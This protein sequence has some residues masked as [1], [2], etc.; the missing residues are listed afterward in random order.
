MTGGKISNELVAL[1]SAVIFAVYLAGSVRTEP[2]ASRFPEHAGTRG[3]AVAADERDGQTTAYRNGIYYGWGYSRHGDIEAYVTIES[4]R[5]AAA[6]IE[7]CQTRYPCSRIRELP[8]QVRDRQS[9][10]VDYVSGATQSAEA[11]YDAVVQA[12][13]KAK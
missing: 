1:S 10:E 13:S 3:A 12:L 4:G 2:E 11:F 8:G 9:A 5:I 6:G 7:R